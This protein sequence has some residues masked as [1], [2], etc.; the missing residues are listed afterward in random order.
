MSTP[1]T[2]YTVSHVEVKIAGVTDS[3]AD[4]MNSLLFSSADPPDWSIEA[5]RH[6]F[7]GNQ[8][9]PETIIS[10][11]QTPKWGTLTLT[12]GWD[13]GYVLAKW[14]AQVEDPNTAIDQKKKQVDV[15]FYK[16][17]GTTELCTWHADAGII[18]SYKQAASS[19]ESNG[20]MT[21]TATIDAD[22]WQQ[23]IG[24]SPISP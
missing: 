11:V 24:G 2:V 12:Q 20:V 15:T 3:S 8:G 13:D 22:K 17:D 10:A 19:P 14:R 16:A 5:T 9:Q 1:P 23:T 6:V 4:G 7:H 21:I 18:T